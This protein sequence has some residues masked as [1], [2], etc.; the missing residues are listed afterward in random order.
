MAETLIQNG[1]RWKS[2]EVA[3]SILSNF[4]LDSIVVYTKLVHPN[5]T[6]MMMISDTTY[7][8]GTQV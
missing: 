8:G 7:S 1:C 6:P 4:A 3:Y 5:I 2:K